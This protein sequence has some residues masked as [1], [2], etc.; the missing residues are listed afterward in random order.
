MTASLIAIWCGAVMLL[1]G[2]ALVLLEMSREKTRKSLP[3]SFEPEIASLGV[4][5]LCLG[6]FLLVVGLFSR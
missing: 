2:V 1:A 5:L 3:H 6:V 4:M